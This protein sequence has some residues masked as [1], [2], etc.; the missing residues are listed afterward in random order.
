M[1]FIRPDPYGSS[2][3]CVLFA[4]V[5][6]ST[7]LFEI[8]GDIEGS[9][10]IRTCLKHMNAATESFG[11]RAIQPVGDGLLTAFPTPDLGAEAAE[12][13]MR[14]IHREPRVGGKHLA[15]RIGLHYGSVIVRTSNIFGGQLN[16]FG[17]TVNVAARITALAKARQILTSDETLALLPFRWRQSARSLNAF[18]LKGKSEDIG[19]YEILWQNPD[20]I[21]AIRPIPQFPEAA[22]GR[23][24]L[25]YH[26]QRFILDGRTRGLAFG[27]EITNDVVIDGR[28]ISR[29]HARIERRRDKFVLIDSSTNG[30]YVTFNGGSE[31]S[32]RMEEI[33]LHGE[34]HFSLGQ[35]YDSTDTLTAF[36]FEVH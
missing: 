35:P 20:T 9:G 11:G 2:T 13:M 3:L 6:G 19:V 26:Q 32:V 34:G 8:L 14:R 27:R 1:D 33:V 30:T 31:L 7:Q 21:T 15:L 5:S 25:R 24:A 28:H 29:Q 12:E 23:L 10:V 16:I 17:D 4:D 22:S 18:S 36:E